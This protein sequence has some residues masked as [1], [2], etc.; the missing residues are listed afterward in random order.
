MIYIGTIVGLACC[1]NA[2]YM[3]RLADGMQDDHT[4]F[5]RMPD[6]IQVCNLGSSHGYYAFDYQ[7]FPE[8]ATMNFAYTSQYLSYDSRLLGYY[9]DHL[10]EDAVV[11]VPISYFVLYGMPE[12]ETKEFISRNSYYYRILPP[13]Q[14]KKYDL[15]TELYSG[16]FASLSAGE[17]LIPVLM[18]N[19]PEQSEDYA[20]LQKYRKMTA[21]EI[22][23]LGDAQQAY[24]RHVVT[25]K[26]DEQGR[27]IRNEEEIR[28]LYDIIDICRAHRARP[29]LLTTP[30][31]REYMDILES[32][33]PEFL[34]DFHDVIGQIVRDTGVEYR[35]YSR[36]ER[37]FDDHSLFL[38]ADHL[39]EEGSRRFTKILM[40]EFVVPH[41]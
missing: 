39:N 30:V 21:D 32:G 17:E 23:L 5:R 16:R 28:A 9:A 13:W 29:V 8:Y 33:S 19:V 34:R 35:D 2:V 40:D 27:M 14:I 12:E 4:R 10:A 37:F 6:S 36:D 41:M 11:F 1:I 20:G 38:N 7:D 3:T 25:N 31:L 24:L 22:D 26:V 18:G 15:R